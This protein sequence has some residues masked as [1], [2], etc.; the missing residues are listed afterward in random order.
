MA[1]PDVQRLIESAPLVKPP[2]DESAVKNKINGTH[3]VAPMLTS[4]ADFVA[5][6]T[7]PIFLARPILQRGQLVSMTART[8]HGKSAV[9]GTVTA[10][11]LTGRSIGPI[12]FRRGRVLLLVGE[13]PDNAAMQ[14]RAATRHYGCTAD[15]L[16]RLHVKAGAARLATITGALCEEAAAIGE[17]DLVIA[18]TSAAFFS[19]DDENDNVM[20]LQHAKDLRLLTL[21]PGNPCVLVP[22]HPVKQATRD[23]LFPRGGGSFLGEMDAN[24]T[25]WKDGETLELSHN[26]LRGPAFDPLH[27]NLKPV[28]IGIVDEQGAPVMTPVAVPMTDLEEAKAAGEVRQDENLLLNTMLRFPNESIAGWADACGWKSDKGI[29]HKSKVHRL[30]LQL[31]ED[32]LA[33]LFRRRWELTEAGK[34]EAR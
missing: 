6:V 26:K 8:N 29:P 30:L 32:K 2:A 34:R 21:L 17:F 19:Y 4:G 13:N 15:D 23:N 27:F 14:V 25:L 9:A 7:A 12:K 10:G 16:S 3:P 20:Q 1:I 31:K 28:D 18:D 33:R 22:S 24:L 5:N 11:V